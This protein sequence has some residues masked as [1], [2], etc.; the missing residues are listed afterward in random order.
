MFWCDSQSRHDYENFSDVLVFD[1]TYKMNRYGM[2][3]IPFACLN[4]HRKTTVF[5]SGIVPDETEETYVWVLQTFLRP[6][7]QKLPK[8]VSRTPMLR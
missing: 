6:M 1:S 4:K 5:G 8:T 2:P 3:F 7:C